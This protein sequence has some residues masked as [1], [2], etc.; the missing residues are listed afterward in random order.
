MIY[1]NGN[2]WTH[3]SD[4]SFTRILSDSIEEIQVVPMILGHKA[5]FS[6]S[7]QL[8]YIFPEVSSPG[9]QLS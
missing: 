8:S 7:F 5:D 9:L 4:F 1:L 6:A 2:I 3:Y